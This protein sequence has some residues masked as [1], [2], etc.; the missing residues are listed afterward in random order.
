M[1]SLPLP[2]KAQ[3][4]SLSLSETYNAALDHATAAQA[5][6]V[7]L[8]RIDTSNSPLTVVHFGLHDPVREG[9]LADYTWVAVPSELNT[10]CRSKPDPVLALEEILGMPPESNGEWHVFR[11]GL[12][13]S[14]LFR[15]C[16]GGTRTNSDHCRPT[17][18]TTTPSGREFDDWL[19]TIRQV[20]E[21]HVTTPGVTRYPFTG[22][23]WTY[24][25]D[26][27]APS[28][29]GVSEYVARPQALVKDETQVSPREFCEQ[30]GSD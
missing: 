30:A 17:F 11:L 27:S 8:T 28:H 18:P 4:A 22:M 14:D 5:D 26:P 3:G 2:T 6:S 16:V 20:W 24:N 29:V 21:S 23:G 7:V 19:F 1:S 10:A 9:R 12:S 13:P 15:P 25:W